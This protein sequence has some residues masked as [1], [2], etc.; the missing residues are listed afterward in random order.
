MGVF[1]VFWIVQMV[2]NRAKH[3]IYQKILLDRHQ[4]GSSLRKYSWYLYHY[5]LVLKLL[6]ISSKT[7]WILLYI[8]DI[9]LL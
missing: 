3:Q 6:K 7:T 9:N 5:I 2:T 4:N 1:H 8:F